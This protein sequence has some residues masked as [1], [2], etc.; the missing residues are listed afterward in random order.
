V[1]SLNTSALPVL[2]K[3]PTDIKF[4]LKRKN[5]E[6]IVELYCSFISGQFYNAFAS[7]GMISTI[8]SLDSSIVSTY[9]LY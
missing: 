9:K 4:F 5:I 6:N 8:C 1:V 7:D 3:A 2:V